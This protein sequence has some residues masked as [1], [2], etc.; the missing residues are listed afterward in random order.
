MKEIVQYAIV[1]KNGL[2]H[3]TTQCKEAAEH[4]MYF[5]KEHTIVKL[6]GQ[7]PEPKKM[8][9]IAQHVLLSSVGYY[10]YTGM[11]TMEEANKHCEK[12]CYQLIKWPHGDVIEVEDL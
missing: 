12:Y 7:M 4:S 5:Q 2:V 3:A 6:T 8:K 10:V 11:L 1:D 9:R